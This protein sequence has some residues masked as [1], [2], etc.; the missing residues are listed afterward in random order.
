MR[1]GFVQWIL[2]EALAAREASIVRKIIRTT[3]E[4]R[5]F[6]WSDLAVA[7][8]FPNLHALLFTDTVLIHLFLRRT[9]MLW[10]PLLRASFDEGVKG[11]NDHKNKLLKR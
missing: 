4:W 10:N 6:G 9:S 1:K 7:D 5:R 3:M 8:R 11:Y 2:L